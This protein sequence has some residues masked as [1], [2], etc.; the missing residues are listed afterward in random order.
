MD[1]K[2]FY[3]TR[4]GSDWGVVDKQ[5]SYRYE[6]GGRWSAM[7]LAACMNGHISDALDMAN[8]LVDKANYQIQADDLKKAPG[9]EKS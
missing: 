1:E 7:I 5:S 9:S 8:V 4:M 2:R 3:A 6:S